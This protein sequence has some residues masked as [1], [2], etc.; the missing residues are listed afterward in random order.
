MKCAVCGQPI[1]EAAQAGGYTTHPSC[2]LDPR[3]QSWPPPGCRLARG[4][5]P[6]HAEYEAHMARARAI[7]EGWQRRP[8][9]RRS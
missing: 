6:A 3:L 2:D 1:Q 4:E 9:G 8:R 5:G 7:E